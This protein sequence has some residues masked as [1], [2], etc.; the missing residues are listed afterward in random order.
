MKN[1][2]TFGNAYNLIKWAWGNSTM[3]N[4]LLVGAIEKIAW[5]ETYECPD[6]VGFVLGDWCIEFEELDPFN[7]HKPNW[8]NTETGDFLWIDGNSPLLYS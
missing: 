3:N 8:I 6:G 1:I 4:N 7:C 5:D 2:T